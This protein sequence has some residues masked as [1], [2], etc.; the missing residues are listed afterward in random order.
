[1]STVAE[2]L[3]PLE[4]AWTRHE[5]GDSAHQRDPAERQAHRPRLSR[6]LRRAL[7]AQQQRRVA[8]FKGLEQAVAILCMNE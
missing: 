4:S 7:L 1:M 5:S 3:E 8:G 2:T 6:I